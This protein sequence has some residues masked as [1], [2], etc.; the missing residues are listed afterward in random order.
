M[1]K[2]NQFGL[3]FLSDHNNKIYIRSTA[4]IHK[5]SLTCY[6]YKSEYPIRI[7]FGEIHNNFS[8]SNF[9]IQF[10]TTFDNLNKEYALKLCLNIEKY[11]NF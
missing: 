10:K 1:T 4:H 11:Y 9:I 3:L 6:N 7:T 5:H 8:Y 2:M